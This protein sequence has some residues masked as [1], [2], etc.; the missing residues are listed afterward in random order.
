MRQQLRLSGNTIFAWP[1]FVLFQRVREALKR[2][3]V[4]KKIVA[5]PARLKTTR[6]YTDETLILIY[7]PSP[8]SLGYMCPLQI[9]FS[10]LPGWPDSRLRL[11]LN[12]L[13]V[14]S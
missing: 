6:N 3:R 14:L 13:K 1:T 2:C 9:G 5:S 8:D 12:S 4:A 10:T 7:L 11:R